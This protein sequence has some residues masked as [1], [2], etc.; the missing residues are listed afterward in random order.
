M[1]GKSKLLSTVLEHK[2]LRAATYCH[3]VIKL[4]PSFLIYLFKLKKK[5]S[6][7]KNKYKKELATQQNNIHVHAYVWILFYY[8]L[9][10]IL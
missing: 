5:T 9:T 3:K 7:Q 10:Y 6:L 2:I 4:L 1:S 8:I